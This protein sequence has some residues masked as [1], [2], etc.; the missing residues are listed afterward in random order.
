MTFFKSEMIML[1]TMKTSSYNQS[2]YGKPWI[3]RLQF[4]RPGKPDYMFGD[5]LGSPGCAGE[6]SVEVAPGDVIAH[7]Q[8]DLR[9]GRG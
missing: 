3:A 7:G 1:F 9:K 4:T 8:K 5:W 6:L 2:R